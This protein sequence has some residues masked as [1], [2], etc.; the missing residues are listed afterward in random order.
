M[1]KK[2]K[3]K[4]AHKFEK[5]DGKCVFHGF[6]TSNEGDM[7]TIESLVLGNFVV[8]EAKDEKPKKIVVFNIHF[9]VSSM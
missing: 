4:K 1:M 8:V 7:K 5:K 3:P 9:F 2:D 6:S